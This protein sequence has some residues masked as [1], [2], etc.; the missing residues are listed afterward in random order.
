MKAFAL[1]VFDEPGIDGL[2][3]DGFELQNFGD[4][5]TGLIN[6][7]ISQYHEAAAGRTPDQFHSG[8]E[9]HRASAFSADEG[10]CHIKSVF[11]K[12]VWKVVAGDTAGNIG[13][14]PPDLV[15]VPVCN[16]L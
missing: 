1:H 5:V 11:R 10:A 9:H 14:S 13:K 12:Q 15:S 4:V 2:T 8:F 16:I 7:R 6:V 3:G